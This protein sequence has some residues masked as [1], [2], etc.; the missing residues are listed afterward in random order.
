M[1]GLID[2]DQTDR[3]V[4]R[5]TDQGV[6]SIHHTNLLGGSHDHHLDIF[7]FSLDGHALLLTN[8]GQ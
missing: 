3:E 2:L 7:I 1:N 8:F 4:K 6:V 5:F